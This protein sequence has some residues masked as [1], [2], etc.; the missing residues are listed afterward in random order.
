MARGAKTGGRKKGS[1]NKFTASAK[2]AFSYAFDDIGGQTALAEWG[3]DNRTDFYKLFA[4]LIPEEKVLS[5]DP[6]APLKHSVE[7]HIVDHRASDKG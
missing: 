4:R 7:F 5:G 2:E 1:R 3:R 6:N